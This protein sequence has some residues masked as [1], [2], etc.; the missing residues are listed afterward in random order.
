M[1][2]CIHSGRVS[3]VRVQRSGKD[4]GYFWA[5][6]SRSYRI[7]GIKYSLESSRS[8][9]NFFCHVF[10]SKFSPIGF[11]PFYCEGETQIDISRCYAISTAPF[12]EF[13]EF[14]A[15]SVF[16]NSCE[17]FHVLNFAPHPSAVTHFTS[18]KRDKTTFLRNMGGYL[19]SQA[20]IKQ[21]K[22]NKL[23][24]QYRC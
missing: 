21:A 9:V 22:Y 23:L 7:Q 18:L 11:H 1:S 15:S 12:Q 2:Q 24:K 20:I 13:I 17:F 19:V 10:N 14:R 3:N 16:W 4:L 5:S 8:F 6:I